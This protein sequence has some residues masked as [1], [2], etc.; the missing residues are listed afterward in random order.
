MST[1][2]PR[3]QRRGHWRAQTRRQTQETWER[4]ELLRMKRREDLLD[5]VG[6]I[7]GFGRLQLRR[8]FL[9]MLVPSRSGPVLLSVSARRGLPGQGAQLGNPV[10]PEA[11]EGTNTRRKHSLCRRSWI[12]LACFSVSPLRTCRGAV[13]GERRGHFA[14]K[15]SLLSPRGF[16]NLT[17]ALTGNALVLNF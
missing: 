6:L 9:K 17:P 4:R 8:D 10:Q 5:P 13:H 14:A 7:F 11:R 2:R 12:S 1:R 3:S 16:E 15:R